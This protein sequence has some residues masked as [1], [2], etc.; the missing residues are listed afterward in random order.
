MI[1]RIEFFVTLGY[2]IALMAMLLDFELKR[3]KGSFIMGLL[4]GL[5]LLCGGITWVSSGYSDFMIFYPIFVQAPLYIGFWFVSKFKGAKLFFVLLTVVV[6]SS[7]PILIGQIVAAFFS[8][9]DGIAG[10]ISF[11]LA[12]PLTFIVYTYFR[13]SFLYM[14][15]HERKGW[16]IFCLIPL[17]YFVFTWLLG[18]YDVELVRDASLLW[19]DTTVAMIIIAAYVLILRH[20]QQTR[21]QLMLQNEQN[22]LALQ[23]AALQERS[24][25]LK[26][27]EEKTR[28]YRH[29]LHHHLQLINGYLAD[30]KLA[31]IEK[32]IVD[33]E[34]N[35][36]ET[37]IIKYCDNNTV[38]L[39]LSPYIHQAQSENIRVESQVDIPKNCK[40]GDMDLCIILSNALENAIKASIHI[41][42][43]GERRIEI[44]C[45]S[46]R[47]K[48]FI[49]VS[50]HFS[51]EVK[52]I[53]DMP[54]STEENHGFGTKSIAA[55]V[56]KYSGLCSFTAE[57]G[58]FKMRVI[59]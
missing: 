31:E 58:I 43:P 4:M 17:S 27:S 1:D 22:I 47:D 30:N 46:K 2:S 9:H 16:A 51:G 18:R 50:N 33:I 24:E 14:L 28:I 42:D 54:V 52:F 38:N 11:V 23:V 10:I 20:F 57:D 44:S 48:L 41:E 32:Y 19:I 5:L 3:N 25:T 36:E 7:I 26:E 59:L 45:R 6:F 12:L 35:I 37:V 29:D 53:E 21:E 55:T 49:Q 15:R 56:Q 8:Y 40:V 13:P 34:K 39:I